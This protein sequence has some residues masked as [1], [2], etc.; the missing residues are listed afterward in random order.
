[1]RWKELSRR[2]PTDHVIEVFILA[3]QL[4]SLSDLTSAVPEH[5]LLALAKGHRGVARMMLEELGVDLSEHSNDIRIQ[6]EQPKTG[7]S[8]LYS[9]VGE[10]F[11]RANEEA[12]TRG[13]NYLGTEHLLLGLLRLDRHYCQK[14]LHDLGVDIDAARSALVKLLG[15]N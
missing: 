14:F 6:K 5:V 13:H 2:N 8:G 11:A 4:A 10:L 3:K 1:M 9:G 7:L 15:E 12:G